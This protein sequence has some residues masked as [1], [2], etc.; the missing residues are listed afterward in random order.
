[1]NHFFFAVCVL[2]G[3]CKYY[4]TV[5]LS[6]LLFCI[7]WEANAGGMLMQHRIQQ[8]FWDTCVL[9]VTRQV[10]Q[11]DCFWS[12]GISSWHKIE[13]EGGSFCFFQILGRYLL[14]VS[15]AWGA[16]R[17]WNK[18]SLAPCLAGTYLRNS[19]LLKHYPTFTLKKS[20]CMITPLFSYRENS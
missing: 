15:Y 9:L 5:Q 1:M 20:M 7:W 17:F 11:R 16:G 13:G 3:Y 12:S 18:C 4:S 6:C 19:L 14:L 8:S 2:L 10:S